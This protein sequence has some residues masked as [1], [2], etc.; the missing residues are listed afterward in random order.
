M[1]QHFLI[2]LRRTF[3]AKVPYKVVFLKVF[4]FSFFKFGFVFKHSA[5]QLNGFWKLTIRK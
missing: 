2:D 1:T 5:N 4:L 3:Y